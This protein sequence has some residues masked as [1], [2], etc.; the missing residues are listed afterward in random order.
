MEAVIPA[1][2]LE[3]NADLINGAGALMLSGWMDRGPGSSLLTVEQ[4]APLRLRAAQ[5]GLVPS[6]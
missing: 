6:A 4:V 5:A 2:I 3:V 1:A